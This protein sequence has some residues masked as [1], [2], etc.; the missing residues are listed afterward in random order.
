[1]P[2]C[3]NL[4]E[5]NPT[6][7]PLWWLCAHLLAKPGGARRG[8]APRRRDRAR[9]HAGT[10]GRGLPDEAT[11]MTVGYPAIA[12][13]ALRRCGNVSV[14]AVLAGDDG[15]RLVRA[16]DRAGVDVEPVPPE[17]M[18]GRHA[19][20]RPR[21]A[22]GRG[23][24]DGH[25]SSRRWGAV[26]PPSPPRRSGC[27][28]GSSPGGDGACRCRSSRPSAAR[29][30]AELETF[31]TTLVSEVA[32]PD[33]VVPMSR[34]ALAA[35]CPAVPELLATDGLGTGPERHRCVGRVSGGRRAAAAAC[36]RQRGGGGELFGDLRRG[37]ARATARRR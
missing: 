21:A 8:L 9:R 17:A 10:A 26:S 33:G 11:V 23:L 5:R 19:P 7:G 32:G 3:R 36:A 2:L 6:C 12:A 30:D 37:R 18:L 16:M 31:S 22:R 24:L 28:C 4:V 13:Q 20:R 34:D 1:M 27:R 14:L 15:H 29:L 25:R 35:E